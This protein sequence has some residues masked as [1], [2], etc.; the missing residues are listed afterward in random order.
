MPIPIEA[1]RS[2][3]DILRTGT[4]LERKQEFVLAVAAILKYVAETFLDDS[5]AVST[6]YSDEDGLAFLD[7]L[8]SGQPMAQASLPWKLLVRWLLK[9]LLKEIL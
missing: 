1:L 9:K 8:V 6:A 4:V 2:I 3:L 5:V 7:G